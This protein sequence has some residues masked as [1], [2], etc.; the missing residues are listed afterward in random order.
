M[1]YRCGP[2]AACPSKPHSGPSDCGRETC[3]LRDWLARIAL[4]GRKDSCFLGLRDSS[5]KCFRYR[6]EAEET[7]VLS[8]GY[9]GFG[10]I[11]AANLTVT[12]ER[13]RLVDFSD[14]G[15]RN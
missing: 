1:L 9:P 14:A 6:V 3:S 12:L 7:E 13:Q 15:L 10:D 8:R 11:A 4:A 2:R 5:A